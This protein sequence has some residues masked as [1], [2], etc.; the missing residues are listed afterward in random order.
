MYLRQYVNCKRHY[1]LDA[2]TVTMEQP[3]TLQE[4]VGMYADPKVAHDTVVAMRWP[5]AVA[6]PRLGCGSADVRVIGGSVPRWLCKDCNR[7]F[8]A[9]TDTVFENGPIGF[10][11]WL[12]ALWLLSANRN[13]ISSCELA[14]ALGVAQKAAWFMLHRIRLVMQAGSVQQIDGE[15]E[16]D[17]TFVGPKARSTKRRGLKPNSGKGPAMNK[18]TVLGFRQRGG[19]VRA[20]VVRDVRRTTLLPAHSRTRRAERDRLNGC[21]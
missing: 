16:I 4:V 7:E 6:C 19:I 20:F 1:I 8:T 2:V 9:K 11:K 12:P 21:A 13:G 15:I 17:E 18:T 5:H 10:D 3:K 14:R